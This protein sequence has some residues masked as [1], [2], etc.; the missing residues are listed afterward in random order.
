M[1]KHFSTLQ[2][3]ILQ[4]LGQNKSISL[5]TLSSIFKL[6][7]SLVLQCLHELIKLNIPIQTIG[8][9][10]FQLMIPYQPISINQNKLK[11]YLMYNFDIIDSTNQF[12]KNNNFNSY[13]VFCHS[14]MQTSG[15]GRLGRTWQSVF[16]TNLYFSSKW[17]FNCNIEK[18]TGLSLVIGLALLHAIETNLGQSDILLKWPNDLVWQDK[19]LAG[20]LIETGRLCSNQCELIIGLGVNVNTSLENM[21]DL[22]RP[23]T[24]LCQIYQ[25]II[26]R[27]ALLQQIIESQMDYMTQFKKNGLKHFYKEWMIKDALIGKTIHVTK[28]DHMISGVS[29]GINQKGFLLIETFDKSILEITSG[30]TTTLSKHNEE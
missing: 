16:G 9:D 18:L 26:D 13:P 21:P 3:Q 25:R 11:S 22:S 24:S 27:N 20:I 8:I 10:Q 14:E 23:W 2:N 6:Q 12:L 17:Q 15:R 4:I 30:E 5:S 29:K 19:K 28:P 7:E 1:N